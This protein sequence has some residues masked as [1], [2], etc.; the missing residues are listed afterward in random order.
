ML[1]ITYNFILIPFTIIGAITFFILLKVTAPYGKFSKKNW[2][3][4]ISYKLGWFLQEVISLITF[5]YFFLTGS[6]EHKSIAWLFFM[7]WNMHYFNRSIIYPLRKK[8][9]SLCPLIIVLFAIIFN[10]INGFING[11]YLG[12]LHQYNIE[13]ILSAKFIVGSFIFILGL[14]INL[15]SD[16]ILLKLKRIDNTYKVPKGF[17][18]NYISCPNYFGEIIEWTGFAIMTWSAPGLIFAL[19][20]FFNLVPRAVSHHKWYISNFEDYPKSR[21]AIIPFIL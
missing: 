7:I 11:F 21:K 10:L 2:G 6:I 19:W 17:L 9:D 8:E 1:E 16:N 4:N 20:T 18:Y 13:Y 3:P 12:N 14:V 15:V 5:S